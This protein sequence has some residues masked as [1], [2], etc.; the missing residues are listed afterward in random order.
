MIRLL[1][2]HVA[3]KIAAGE[4]VDRPLSVVKELVENSIDAGADTITVEI[5]KG[6][7]TYIRVSDNGC[8][9]HSDEVLTA[10]KRHATSKI[11]EVKDLDTISTLGFRGEALASICAVSRT[12]LIT[13][14]EDEKVGTKVEIDG[15]QT[16]ETGPIG[17]DN[18]TTVVVKDLFY[19][20]PARLKFMKSDSAE[21]T[22]II[23]FMSQIALCYPDIRIRVINNDAM[24]FSTPGKGDR[25]NAIATIYGRTI[26]KALVPVEY[27]LDG[28]KITGFVSN[29]G[30]SRNSRK[31]Q[32]FFVN[33]RVIQSKVMD[34]AVKMAYQ[35]RLFQGRFPI[36]FLFL[37]V[38]ADTLD[39][40]IHPNK[41]E[42]R[43]DNER[44]VEEFTVEGIKRALS[45]KEAAPSVNRE[46]LF[47]IDKKNSEKW[48][49]KPARTVS[50]SIKEEISDTVS[51]IREENKEEVIV[52]VAP[53]ESEEQLNVKELLSTLR[54]ETK[55]A[56]EPIEM[57]RKPMRSFDF[58]DLKINGSVFDTYIITEDGENM[59]LIDQHAAHERIFYEKFRKSFEDEEKSRQMI[60]AP[61]LIEIPAAVT[62]FS[63][64][65]YLSQAGYTLEEFG[66]RTYRVTE[67]PYF[68]NLTEAEDFIN[69]YISSLGSDTDF[70]SQKIND[71][72]AKKACKAAIKGNQHISDEEMKAL[73]NDLSLCDNPYSCPHG[74][75]TYIKMSRNQIERMFRRV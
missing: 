1:E 23:D 33:G 56:E 15:S 31:N 61:F 9:I 18:G 36:C 32:I 2:K 40:N 38:P 45:V 29:T 19:N 69:D 75:P 53:K 5:R 74:R 66:N 3:D 37:E 6:G 20:T 41:R 71:D 73:L 30:E 43:F 21:A 44:A 51:E 58:R 59:Y 14:T 46:K 13:R 48:E 34:R 52:N 47:R 28:M 12:E 27:E 72:I 64:L 60:L 62:D 57:I 10:F 22:L 7:K 50:Q 11:T 16:A 49:R 8:G 65:E 17:C 35:E 4:V 39:V 54:T 70:S 68:M 55:A 42:V 26:A 63:F 24:L 67:I 25:L